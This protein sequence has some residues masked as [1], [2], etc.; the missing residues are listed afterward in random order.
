VKIKLS[1]ILRGEAYGFLAGFLP[2][3]Y[4]K[5]EAIATSA[6]WYLIQQFAEV[7]IVREGG[8]LLPHQAEAI[9]LLAAAE[10]RAQYGAA[11]QRA[12]VGPGPLTGLLLVLQRRYRS[13]VNSHDSEYVKE[14]SK[15]W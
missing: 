11:V 1:T 2:R 12:D 13:I 6:K 7:A 14:E 9:E 4:A 15:T 5:V 10:E 8:K 3:R